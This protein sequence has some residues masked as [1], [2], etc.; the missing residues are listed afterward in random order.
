MPHCTYTLVI[1]AHKVLFGYKWEICFWCSH[2][3]FG[4]AR[5]PTV[6]K[7]SQRQPPQIQDVNLIFG[8]DQAY[9]PL[10]ANGGLRSGECTFSSGAK[11]CKSGRTV[12]THQDLRKRYATCCMFGRLS[13]FLSQHSPTS[14]HAVDDRPSLEASAGL[15]GRLPFNTRCMTFISRSSG[16]GNLPVKIWSRL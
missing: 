6:N 10:E 13:L 14:F 11:P 4:A 2:A 3:L 16:K 8:P 12:S 7:S 1:V 9:K 15:E 5:P